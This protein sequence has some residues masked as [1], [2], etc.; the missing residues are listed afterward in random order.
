MLRKTIIFTIFRIYVIFCLSPYLYCETENNELMQRKK[1][2]S[3]GYGVSDLGVFCPLV[4]GPIDNNLNI[5]PQNEKDHEVHYKLNIPGRCV[6]EVKIVDKKGLI[7]KVLQ[8]TTKKRHVYKAGKVITEN[9]QVSERNMDGELINRKFIE[10]EYACINTDK[11]KPVLLCLKHAISA[12]YFDKDG[13][14][15]SIKEHNRHY[16]KNGQLT[17][18]ITK[19]GTWAT[20]DDEE[21]WKEQETSRYITYKLIKDRTKIT[22]ELDSKEILYE[23]P[24]NEQIIGWDQVEKK[25]TTELK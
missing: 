21:V 9:I 5:K 19:E 23:G 6:E 7:G 24:F 14:L 12:R 10:K 13:K 17:Y 4:S 22:T 3:P 1:A 16:K 11:E 2:I 20:K 15:L 25:T 18:E 8:T